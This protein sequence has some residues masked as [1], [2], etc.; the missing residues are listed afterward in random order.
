MTGGDGGHV[1][2]EG[3]RVKAFGYCRKRNAESRGKK[4]ALEVLALARR[5]RS[6][7]LTCRRLTRERVN[8]V[9]NRG[10]RGTC[11]SSGLPLTV[12]EAVGVGSDDS[13]WAPGQQ[14]PHCEGSGPA[15]AGTGG[16]HATTSSTSVACAIAGFSSATTCGWGGH[17]TRQLRWGWWGNRC[18]VDEAR[19]PGCR[20]ARDASTS[21]ALCQDLV[22]IPASERQ[23]LR[24]GRDC[25]G[26]EARGRVP[27]G[28][29]GD[30][31]LQAAGSAPC[32][33]WRKGGGGCL[34]AMV[35]NRCLSPDGSVQTNSQRALRVSQ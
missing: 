9:P 13:R 7:G 33:E 10:Q 21:H 30:F 31:R 34:G 15:R 17:L 35:R 5:A 27:D 29:R 26:S 18:R 1:P 12:M 3:G 32:I 8:R 19:F 16:V 25:H 24:V 6:K 28:R 4:D 23:L 14:Q 11:L 20:V 22:R 2:V